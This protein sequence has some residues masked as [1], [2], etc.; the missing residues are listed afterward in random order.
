MVN[1]SSPSSR[2][3]YTC[4]HITPNLR[5]YKIAIH[6]PPP[7]FD[8]IDYLLGSV[9]AACIFFQV[10]LPSAPPPLSFL[11]PSTS[12]CSPLSS[13]SSPPSSPSIYF[14]E[15]IFSR[16]LLPAIPLASVSQPCSSHYSS[17]SMSC[18]AWTLSLKV[19][20][21]PLLPP[22]SLSPPLFVSPPLPS[23]LSRLQQSRF[24]WYVILGYK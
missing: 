19:F 17:S 10:P 6:P 9:S 21:P 8:P 22:S 4:T 14:E 2:L 13:F 1:S 18:S 5:E 20:T 12:L 7:L 3:A 24:W 23:D 15:L 11:V 16:S